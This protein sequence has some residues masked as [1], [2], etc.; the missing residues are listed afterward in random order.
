MSQPDDPIDEPFVDDVRRMLRRRAADV[1]EAE[2]DR[3]LTARS[4]LTNRAAAPPSGPASPSRLD[5][6]AP[7]QVLDLPPGE[8]GP[9]P[10]EE[11]AIPWARRAGLLAAAAAVV[12]L[13]GLGLARW[14]DDDAQP[15][16]VGAD[17]GVGPSVLVPPDGDPSTVDSYDVMP[18]DDAFGP[19]DWLE[20]YGP[21]DDATTGLMVV[22]EGFEGAGSH[23][24]LLGTD[25]R[26]VTTEESPAL[27]GLGAQT[28][29]ASTVSWTVPSL[30]GGDGGHALSV[31]WY[32]GELDFVDGVSL[33][34]G[35]ATDLGQQFDQVAPLPEGWTRRSR[36]D[37]SQ[38]STG[39]YR[40]EFG[41]QPRA[42]LMVSPFALPLGLYQ[43]DRAGGGESVEVTAV[44]VRGEAG[45][46]FGPLVPGDDPDGGLAQVIWNEGGATHILLA[47][48][49]ADESVEVAD[50]A[51][52]LALAERLV[53][54]DVEEAERRF[55]SRLGEEAMATTTLPATSVPVTTVPGPAEADGEVS[56]TAPGP[57]AIEPEVSLTAPGPGDVTT[58]DATATT[59]PETVT[60]EPSDSFRSTPP[61]TPT[62]LRPDLSRPAG[63]FTPNSI[64]PV[65][66]SSLG[67]V[68]YEIGVSWSPGFGLCLGVDLDGDLTGGGYPVACEPEASIG[69]GGRREV[70]GVGTVVFAFAPDDPALARAE[71][72]VGGTVHAATLHRVDEFPSFAF[73]VLALEG[74]PVTEVDQLLLPGAIALYDGSGQPLGWG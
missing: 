48:P 55:G 73:V 7:G 11:S 50:P 36:I 22:S 23:S 14:L 31:V 28:D 52:L 74:V 38:A 42:M 16:A 33:A 21:P 57:G 64:V 45:L 67:G 66:G 27:A 41:G 1:P 47:F 8:F 60:T 32:G 49:A 24:G 58:D 18:L 6:A 26:L 29:G 4:G 12:A 17:G 65:D 63:D 54:I 20:D 69:G 2:L 61:P 10:A 13:A 62:S 15:V 44:T 59:I 5:P 71:L 35:R 43:I 19:N 46:V 40:V 51:D 37:A 72:T 56:L 53:P 25:G 9:T 70:P 68:D 39:G 34:E 3:G 30:D